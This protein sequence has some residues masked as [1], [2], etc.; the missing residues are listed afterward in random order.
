VFTSLTSS[1]TSL[2]VCP[3]AET[4]SLTSPT[5]LEMIDLFNKRVFWIVKEI[6]DDK[7]DD[8]DSCSESDRSDDEGDT[9][10][11]VKALV[12]PRRSARTSSART[13]SKSSNT[14]IDRDIRRRSRKS[15]HYGGSDAV[16]STD[17]KWFFDR[18][19]RVEYFIEV[20]LVLRQLGNFYGLFEVMLALTD[21]Y[22]SRLRH[23]WVCLSLP[24]SFG[25]FQSL[26][27]VSRFE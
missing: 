25:A 21:P 1:N 9:T 14:A 7:D 11:V 22:V 17:R 6:I 24:F 3:G 4:K 27:T 26:I 20:A 5:V 13:R 12:S 15:P 10:E 16:S 8:D 19:A 18:A 2:C 23:T